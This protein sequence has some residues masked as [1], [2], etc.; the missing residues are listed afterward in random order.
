MEALRCGAQSVSS[1]PYFI[2]QGLIV[3]LAG[4]KIESPKFYFCEKSE[5]WHSC[6][7]LYWQKLKSIMII[8]ALTRLKI[9]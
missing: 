5:K 3:T 9:L 6:S 7:H 1:Y 2:Y 4:S 8:M